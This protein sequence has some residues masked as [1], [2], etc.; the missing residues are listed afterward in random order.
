M[1][2]AQ[3]RRPSWEQRNIYLLPAGPS[4]RGASMES[5]F[6]GIVFPGGFLFLFFFFF[7]VPKDLF[8]FRFSRKIIVAKIVV[9]VAVV[10]V[11]GVS[12]E[13]ELCCCA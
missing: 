4:E 7:C 2:A 12:T 3:G 1:W 6:P 5:C 8:R 13:R 11:D 10:V 9:V